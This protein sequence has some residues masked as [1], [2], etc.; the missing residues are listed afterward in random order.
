MSDLSTLQIAALLAPIIILQLGL[1]V[2]ALIDL[3]R[4]DR[5]VRGGSKIVW[6]LIV[7]FVNVI[8]PIVYFL[9]GRDER[10]AGG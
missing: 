2:A 3:D 6:A 10:G 8:G 9:V 4:S 5:R 1:M 7:V